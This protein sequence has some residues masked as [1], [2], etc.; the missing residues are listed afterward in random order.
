MKWLFAG[1]SRPGYVPADSLTAEEKVKLERLH[2]PNWGSVLL[3]DTVKL[4]LA[5]RGTQ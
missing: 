2:G 5:E 3:I 4:L 1:W